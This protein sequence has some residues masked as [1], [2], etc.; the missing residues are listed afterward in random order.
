M[1]KLIPILAILFVGGILLSS[2]HNKQKCAAY[3]NV[4]VEQTEG[5]VVE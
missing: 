4:D 5:A 2:C 3:S 1:K